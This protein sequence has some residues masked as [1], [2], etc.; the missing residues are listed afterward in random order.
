MKVY[1]GNKSASQ[2]LGAP[3]SSSH[4]PQADDDADLMD[5]DE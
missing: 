3:T 4:H 1:E 2:T 5:D